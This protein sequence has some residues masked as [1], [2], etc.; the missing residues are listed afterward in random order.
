MK[1]NHF[2]AVVLTIGLWVGCAA[3]EE[4]EEGDALKHIANMF[5]VQGRM[6]QLG[7]RDIDTALSAT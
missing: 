1:V 6:M 5:N 3:R 7:K 2:W 4:E